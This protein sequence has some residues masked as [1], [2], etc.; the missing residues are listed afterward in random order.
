MDEFVLI[1]S[2]VLKQTQSRSVKSMIVEF[3]YVYV[4]ERRER[5]LYVSVDMIRYLC[6]NEMYP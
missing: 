3:Y 4:N 6:V 2:S 5:G 1:F